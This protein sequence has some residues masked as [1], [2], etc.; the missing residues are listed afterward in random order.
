MLALC[1]NCGTINLI[2]VSIAWSAAKYAQSMVDS[3]ELEVKNAIDLHYTVQK[4][5]ELH[6]QQRY[7][8]KILMETSCGAAGAAGA[9]GAVDTKKNVLSYDTTAGTSISMERVQRR[10]RLL[11]QQASCLFEQ[12]CKRNEH[13]V[14]PHNQPIADVG[15]SKIATKASACENSNQRNQNELFAPEAT[16]PSTSFIAD[17]HERALNNSSDKDKARTDNKKEQNHELQL[18]AVQKRR[19]RLLMTVATGRK[20]TGRKNRNEGMGMLGL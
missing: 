20:L 18:L 13:L 9:A 3:I 10:A 6:A 14:V 5:K 2:A 12:A 19:A 11:A 17:E 15:V 1:T 7:G 8:D 16:S 4:A